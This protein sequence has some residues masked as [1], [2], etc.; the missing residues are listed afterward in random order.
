M[1]VVLLALSGCASVNSVRYTDEEIYPATNPQDIKVFTV[2]PPREYVEIGEVRIGAPV[3]DIVQ[4]IEELRG[5]VAQMGGEAV[6]LWPNESKGIVIR[7][8]E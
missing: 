4:T 2:R 8:K 7:F 1:L 6:I 3:N 5:R